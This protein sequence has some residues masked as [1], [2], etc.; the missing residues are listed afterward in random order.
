MYFGQP[1]LRREDNRFLR[2]KGNFTDDMKL[3]NMT[4]AAFVRSTHAHANLLSI[5]TT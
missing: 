5:D 2:G 1:L 4:F 3:P